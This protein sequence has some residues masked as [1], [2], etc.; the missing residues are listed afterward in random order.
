[1]KQ[2]L[3]QKLVD[4]GL[5]ESRRQ[6]ATLIMAGRVYVD[7]ERRDKPGWQVKPEVSVIV[8]AGN[9][10]VSRAA[11]KLASAV[12]KLNLSFK[13]KIV[14]DVGASTG[15]FTDFALQHGAKHVYAIDVG[16]GQLHG[17]LRENPRVTVMEKTDIRDVDELPQTPDIAVVDVSFISLRLVLPAV[18]RLIKPDGRL[19]AMAKPQFE[20]GRAEATKYRGVIKNDTIRRRILKELELWL[21]Q[22]FLVLDKA[23]SAV[24][25]AKGNVERFFLLKMVK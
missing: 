5:A 24:A 6:A 8:K 10:F 22:H 19:L 18:G 3:D 12:R 20:A 1:M 7:G 14:L 4:E 25:G 17:T 23:D 2:R 11:L 16:T 9:R 21:R 13:D 15:G